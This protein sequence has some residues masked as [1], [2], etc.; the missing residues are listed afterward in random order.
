M[1]NKA[2]HQFFQISLPKFYGTELPIQVLHVIE[3]LSFSNQD[4]QIFRI[5]FPSPLAY[6]SF[7]SLSP[8]S[9]FPFEVI[10]FLISLH[11]LLHLQV[12]EHFC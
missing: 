2:V 11:F 5:T 6:L 7:R 9:V 8:P 1:S 4:C 12:S 10:S 3:T